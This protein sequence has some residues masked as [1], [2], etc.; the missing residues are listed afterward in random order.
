MCSGSSEDQHRGG[1]R[2]AQRKDWRQKSH[3][4]I[5]KIPVVSEDKKDL[6][7]VIGLFSK[8]FRIHLDEVLSY[9]IELLNW[10][11]FGWEIGLNDLQRSLP[12]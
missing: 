10:S 5:R 11:C 1:S 4:A 3:V 7:D 12:A 9:M 8:R 2:D 6:F